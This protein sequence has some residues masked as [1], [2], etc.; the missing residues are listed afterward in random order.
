MCVRVRARVDACA[1]S[2]KQKQAAPTPSPTPTPRP[3]SPDES[4]HT[5]G[6]THS[7][8]T[9][10][11]G[12]GHGLRRHHSRQLRNHF[13]AA[14]TEEVCHHVHHARV[15]RLLHVF[16]VVHLKHIA[17]MMYVSVQID[18]YIDNSRHRHM[19]TSIHRYIGMYTC[20]YPYTY[21]CMHMYTCIHIGIYRMV[22]GQGPD[23]EAAELLIDGPPQNIV[24]RL[25]PLADTDT[26]VTV[27]V[28]PRARARA[29]PAERDS[30]RH[31]CK[32]S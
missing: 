13:I 15:A 9:A 14:D 19:D 27:C 5:P 7:Q 25:R 6:N 4:M 3:Q 21:A 30:K 8:A 32:L 17:Y 20:V 12:E 24:Q 31:G 11:P 28:H 23:T 29:L 1:A 26:S 10:A 22:G 16:P 2:E 18:G